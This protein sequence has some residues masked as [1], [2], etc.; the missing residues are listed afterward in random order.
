MSGS[1]RTTVEDLVV[2]TVLGDLPARRLGRMNTHEHLLMRDPVL[3]GEELD[4]PERSAAEVQRLQASGFDAVLELTALGLGRDPAGLAGIARQTGAHIVMATGIHHE[5]HYAADHPFRELSIDAMAQ[6]FAADLVDG[7]EDGVRAGVIKVGTGYWRISPFERRVL[8]AAGQAHAST[9][10]AVVC[11]LELGTAAFE[12]LEL[13]GRAGV[14]ADRVMLAHIDRNPDP[15]LHTELA[16][17]GAYLGYDGWSRSKY[18]PDSTLIECLLASV[19]RGAG[20]RIVLGGDVARRSAFHAYDGLPGLAY[21]GDRVLPRIR[22][23]AGADLVDQLVV[24]NPSRLLA[25][26]S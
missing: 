14:P 25:R 26:P 9:Q 3:P 7:A 24:D 19:A 11:H 10:A 4:D 6:R 12:V 15:G 23:A 21:L 5:G 1:D 16:A 17:A 8:E 13:L 20:E 22:Q 2:T 18:H